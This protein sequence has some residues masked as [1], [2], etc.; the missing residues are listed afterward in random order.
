[1]FK[2]LS[3]SAA[4]VLT[5]CVM[6]TNV[7]AQTEPEIN[8]AGDVYGGGKEGHVGVGNVA[9]GKEITTIATQMSLKQDVANSITTHYSTNVEINDGKVR[10]VSGEFCP[11][12]KLPL[13]GWFL[14]LFF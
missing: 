12:I 11:C 3:R 1:M 6:S 7:Y 4:L 5:A 14:P 10:T 8:I 13:K 2:K 9:E